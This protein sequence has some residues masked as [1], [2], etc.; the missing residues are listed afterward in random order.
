MNT[1]QVPALISLVKKIENKKIPFNYEAI[2]E[3]FKKFGNTP[4]KQAQWFMEHY[5]KIVEKM[6]NEGKMS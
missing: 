2:F 3:E 5:E 1:A 4:E 6:K